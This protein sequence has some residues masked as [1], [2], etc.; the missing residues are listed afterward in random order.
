MSKGYTTHSKSKI[1]SV[2][3]GEEE[4]NVL[5]SQTTTSDDNEEALAGAAA[6][7][8]LLSSPT[9]NPT[10]QNLSQSPVKMK[11]DYHHTNHCFLDYFN[12]PI[13]DDAVIYM[14]DIPFQCNKIEG[15]YTEFI[16]NPIGTVFIAAKRDHKFLLSQ[17]SNK[18]NMLSN[19]INF[20]L[21]H[22]TKNVATSYK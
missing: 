21:L 10:G 3:H 4:N 19:S 2:I 16:G 18:P 9:A 17:R 7:L 20:G 14:S 1:N 15:S 22:T 13:S 5:L 12:D 8:N 11:C 6:T